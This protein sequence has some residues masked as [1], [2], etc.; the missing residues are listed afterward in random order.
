MEKTKVKPERFYMIKNKENKDT[1]F[2]DIGYAY[3]G[4]K[5]KSD[6]RRWNES[7][8]ISSDHD[9]YEVTFKKVNKTGK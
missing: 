3:Y 4:F 7:A 1:W 5:S 8:N 9:L 2:T 6:Y